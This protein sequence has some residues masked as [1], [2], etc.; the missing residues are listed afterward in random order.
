LLV[1]RDSLTNHRIV[2]RE[3]EP[4]PD[5]AFQQTTPALPDLVHVDRIPGNADDLP[6]QPCLRPTVRFRNASR[7]I[8]RR[9]AKLLD[10][11]EQ[12]GPED[13]SVQLALG[14]RDLQLSNSTNR[15][16]AFQ[17]TL[18]LNPHQPEAYG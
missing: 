12:H 6:P 18:Q 9:I 15:D 2:A 17:H 4:W 13:A 8:S 1:E 14:R 10:D 7:S 3:G 11:L 5:A 16:R